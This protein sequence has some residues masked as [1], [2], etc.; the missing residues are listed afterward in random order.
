[1]DYKKLL[2]LIPFLV[3]LVFVVFAWMKILTV[4]HVARIRHLISGGLVLVNIVVYL[5]NFRIGILLTGITLLLA[6][7]NFAIITANYTTVR[8]WVGF[9]DARLTLPTIQPWGLL[10]FVLFLVLNVRYLLAAFDNPDTSS[11]S[12]EERR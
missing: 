12:V 8:Y 3:L 10:L 9:G 1:M 6:S 5:F 4:T 7:F 11:G 2:R